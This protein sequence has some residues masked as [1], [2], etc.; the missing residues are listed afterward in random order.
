MFSGVSL[1]STIARRR[2]LGVIMQLQRSKPM[3]HKDLDLVSR[4]G[5]EPTTYGLKVAMLVCFC[6]VRV[7]IHRDLGKRANLDET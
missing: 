7:N 4:V 2:H 6:S 3:F 1:G 5:L